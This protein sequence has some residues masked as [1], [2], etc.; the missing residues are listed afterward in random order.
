VPSVVQGCLLWRSKDAEVAL[1]AILQDLRPVLAIALD[2]ALEART[3]SRGRHQLEPLGRSIS[4]GL[5]G[6]EWLRDAN[7]RS[8]DRGRGEQL[9]LFASHLRGWL[10]RERR[11]Q[12]LRRR[13]A[14][15][16]A[17]ARQYRVANPMAH[18]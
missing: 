18:P 8:P 3:T 6:G 11:L 17:A 10:L 15:L 12:T 1:L 7:S 13:P 9:R 2:H 14:V 16:A 4:H 5:G